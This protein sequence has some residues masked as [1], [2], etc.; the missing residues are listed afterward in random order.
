MCIR[1]R[2][3]RN[4]QSG[5]EGDY[6]LGSEKFLHIHDHDSGSGKRG[7]N[8]HG[9]KPFIEDADPDLERH[10]REFEGWIRI[11]EFGRRSIRKIDVLTMFG[12]TFPPASTRRSVFDNHWR[13]AVTNDRLP[14]EA[15][16]VLAELQEDLKSYIWE[17]PMMKKIRMDKE[18]KEL[19]QGGLTHARFRAAF[20]NKLLDLKEAGLDLP[21]KE[22]LFLGYLTRLNDE[23][24]TNCLAKEYRIDGEDQPPRKAATWEELAKSCAIYLSER[25]NIRTTTRARGDQLNAIDERGA[26]VPTTKYGKATPPAKGAKVG[27][28]C[29]YCHGTDHTKVVCPQ[30]AADERGQNHIRAHPCSRPGC[31]SMT[32]EERHHNMA[33]TDYG[34]READKAR[35]KAP[36]AREKTSPTV[37][38]GKGGPEKLPKGGKAGKGKGKSEGPKSPPKGGKAG[39]TAEGLADARKPCPYGAKCRSAINEGTCPNKHP[40]AEL[41]LIHI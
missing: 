22:N 30:V 11:N 38:P 13:R 25:A 17:T 37:P 27:S 40:Y 14:Q 6:S 24:A 23:L 10:I 16:A 41:S 8:N 32:H 15:V 5:D 12:D 35:T 2:S 33:V 20:E 36:P 18:W 31:G 9:N 7:K 1:D 26:I 21:T 34:K 19:A 4:S 3:K 39:A 28:S 29:T